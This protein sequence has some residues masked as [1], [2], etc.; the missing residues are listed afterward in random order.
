MEFAHQAIDPIPD[1]QKRSPRVF[2]P[3]VDVPADASPQV[4]FLAWAGR[5][6]RS[7]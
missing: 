2:G 1:Q 6:A 3:V 7:S 4:Q 5:D